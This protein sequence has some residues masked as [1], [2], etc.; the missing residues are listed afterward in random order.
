MPSPNM[1]KITAILAGLPQGATGAE[2]ASHLE[3]TH[4]SATQSLMRLLM[5]GLV[6]RAGGTNKVD[7]TWTLAAAAS[8]NT[9]PIFR[10]METLAAMQG[11]ARQ[12]LMTESTLEAA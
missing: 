8:S 7:A 5:R 4:D 1:P 11:V 9:P 6:E 3:T 12:R 10:A 2:I